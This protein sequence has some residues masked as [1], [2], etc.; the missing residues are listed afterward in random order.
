MV[1]VLW[2]FSYLIYKIFVLHSLTN[3]Y[4][5]IFFWRI[6]HCIYNSHISHIFI[7]DWVAHRFNMSYIL[8]LWK[9]FSIFSSFER[10]AALWKIK[11]S[12]CAT[13][14]FMHTFMHT[15]V[16]IQRNTHH[17]YTYTHTHI[18]THKR[19]KEEIISLLTFCL[20]FAL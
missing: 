5:D 15:Y 13:H 16:D 6:S 17:K 7:V 3:M 2:V 18:N 10:K 8:L 4:V 19:N 12:T 11:Y 9:Y 14:M 20:C 1:F